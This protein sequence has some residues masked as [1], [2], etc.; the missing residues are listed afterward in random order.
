MSQQAQAA[1]SSTHGA[2]SMSKSRVRIKAY[3]CDMT[4]MIGED[5]PGRRAHQC[6]SRCCQVFTHHV[7]EPT[8]LKARPRHFQAFISFS[9][10]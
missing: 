7:K 8:G 1:I 10:C 4:P 3:M 6:R 2:R 5:I 9:K